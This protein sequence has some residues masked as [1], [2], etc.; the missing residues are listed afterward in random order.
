MLYAASFGGVATA[1]FF[2]WRHA[3]AAKLLKP[4]VTRELEVRIARRS[5]AVPIACALAILLAFV[6][7]FLAPLS[8]ML[9]PLLAR[10]L[11]PTSRKVKSATA[12]ANE[13]AAA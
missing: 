8:F 9:I 11:D 3:V 5:M 12:T 1:K 6:S 4:E 7:I 10:L 13:E 2:I